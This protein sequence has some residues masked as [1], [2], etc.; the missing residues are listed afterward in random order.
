[1]KNQIKSL[2]HERRS[3]SKTKFKGVHEIWSYLES[4]PS[5]DNSFY[6]QGSGYID[7]LFDQI[8][9]DSPKEYIKSIALII[10]N[11]PKYIQYE[12]YKHK[13][14]INKKQFRIL[15]YCLLRIIVSGEDNP[16]LLVFLRNLVSFLPS[17]PGLWDS[18]SDIFSVSLLDPVSGCLIMK[19]DREVSTL[20]KKSLESYNKLASEQKELAFIAKT[21]FSKLIKTFMKG[22][23]AASTPFLL[24]LIEILSYFPTRRFTALFLKRTWFLPLV[25]GHIEGSLLNVL[26]YLIY[27]PTDE[28]QSNCLTYEHSDKIISDRLMRFISIAFN[29]YNYTKFVKCTDILTLTKNSRKFAQCFGKIPTKEPLINFCKDMDIYLT[30]IGSLST[31]QLITCLWYTIADFRTIDTRIVPEINLDRST[32]EDIYFFSLFLEA[33]DM[34]KRMVLELRSHLQVSAKAHINNVLDRLNIKYQDNSDSVKISGFS[35]YAMRLNHAPILSHTSDYLYDMTK[36]CV[37]IQIVINFRGTAKLIQREWENIHKNEM[38]YLILFTGD[39]TSVLPTIVSDVAESTDSRIMRITVGLENIVFDEN[40]VKRAQLV[41]KPNAKV[42]SVT[43]RYLKQLKLSRTVGKNFW[44]DSLFDKKYHAGSGGAFILPNSIQIDEMLVTGLQHLKKAKTEKK[45]YNITKREME[46]DLMINFTSLESK[47]DITSDYIKYLGKEIDGESI[48]LNSKQS[49]AFIKA[50]SPGCT[51]I[52]GRVNTGKSELAKHFLQIYS[53]EFDERTI[54]VVA[55]ENLENYLMQQLNLDML[56]SNLKG[57]DNSKAMYQSLLK[58]ASN[59]AKELGVTDENCEDISSCLKLYYNYI[60]PIWKNFERELNASSISKDNI[61]DHFPFIGNDENLK[62]CSLEEIRLKAVNAFNRQLNI[63]RALRS[64]KFVECLHDDNNLFKFNLT[65]ASKI[66][67]ATTTDLRVNDYD[68]GEFDNLIVMNAECVSLDDLLLIPLKNIPKRIVITGNLFWSNTNSFLYQIG[69]TVRNIMLTEQYCDE[70]K[71]AM[72][73]SPLVLSTIPPRGFSHNLQFMDIKDGREEVHS[74]QYAN[75]KEAEFVAL[76]FIYMRRM[77]FDAE[78]I[79]LLTTSELQKVLIQE[80]IRNFYQ[81]N[82]AILNDDVINIC[83]VDEMKSNKYDYLVV[84]LVDTENHDSNSR[85]TSLLICNLLN[86]GAKG[87]YIFGN[88]KTASDMILNLIPIK[89]DALEL[90]Q[91]KKIRKI[92]SGSELQSIIKSMSS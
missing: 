43:K 48:S 84:S 82:T 6:L 37:S 7:F 27:Y 44:I 42:S 45:N 4:E 8:N 33:N 9:R 5:Q 51:F 90:E 74:G 46:K 32:N 73:D 80:M 86:C 1:M 34:M 41:V 3:R 39:K 29:A 26:Q 54:V 68:L 16:E 77:G 76:T 23:M 59:V 79:C 75:S 36:F 14:Q 64:L 17:S 18:I 35:K 40:L 50:M 21:W 2:W 83:T 58:K 31:D 49:D 85:N 65:A 81:E 52:N 60:M 87:I 61:F 63:F 11:C 91:G 89:I 92:S 25:Q 78:Q 13:S 12:F 30:D 69:N 57:N 62:N 47:I 66:I 55:S 28:I 71:I 67:I 19:S 72:T 15:I 22:D 70:K 53:S 56:V 10:N 20:L 38:I 24:L 88:K